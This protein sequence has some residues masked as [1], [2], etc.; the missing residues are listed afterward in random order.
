MPSGEIHCSSTYVMRIQGLAGGLSQE[1][2][3]G[4]SSSAVTL[5]FP[6]H[7]AFKVGLAASLFRTQSQSKW[8]RDNDT[9]G[10]FG[11]RSSS[12]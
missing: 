6:F 10:L 11:F 1:G 2:H 7:A 5:N 4:E 9:S 12:A 3:C 8:A